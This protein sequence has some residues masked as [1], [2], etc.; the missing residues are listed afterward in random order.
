M[1]V[2]ETASTLRRE[3]DALWAEAENLKAE[4]GGLTAPGQGGWQGRHDM[5]KC[6]DTLATGSSAPVYTGAI[7]TT[8]VCR[9]A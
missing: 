2:A 4:V 9:Q 5:V 1:Q 8:S 6:I 3:R 7:T